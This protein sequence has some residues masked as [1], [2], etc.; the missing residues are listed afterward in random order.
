MKHDVYHFAWKVL[1]PGLLVGLSLG[2]AYAPTPAEGKKLKRA[3]ADHPV[4]RLIE[5]TPIGTSEKRLVK[6]VKKA[7]FSFERVVWN[8]KGA[9]ARGLVGNPHHLKMLNERGVKHP[10]FDGL[11]DKGP[12]F[13]VASYA[14]AKA[15]YALMDAKV[16]SLGYGIN[17]Q[18]QRDLDYDDPARVGHIRLIFSE[19]SRLCSDLK[20]EESDDYGN[21]RVFTCAKGPGGPLYARY[22]ATQL[23]SLS[24]LVHPPGMRDAKR[25]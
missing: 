24:I 2:L 4:I 18:A 9:M 25:D 15:V 23:D 13:V 1:L 3:E 6:M 16:W 12:T 19:L 14:G 22:D 7:G 20:V 10:F 11:P 17:L 21:P 8:T 5:R